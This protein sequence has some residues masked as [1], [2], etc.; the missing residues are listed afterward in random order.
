MITT[1]PVS[2]VA[3]A[4]TDVT[5][6]VVA[7][8]AGPLTYQWTKDGANIANA[9]SST[10][11]LTSVGRTN[12]GSYAVVVTGGGGPTTSV[13]AGVRVI[14]PQRLQAPLRAAG[15]QFQLLFR[16][17]DGLLAGDLTRF[18]VHHTTNF[19]GLGTVWLTN[20]GSLTVSNGMLL[21][22]DSGSQG[23]GRRFYRVIEK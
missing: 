2:Q 19:I 8:G 23:L 12:S 21:F 13:S 3:I 10:L 7:T 14:V 11:L 5:L 1:P 22:D 4:G 18:E 17:H 6:S 20:S 9:T 15:G 16:D